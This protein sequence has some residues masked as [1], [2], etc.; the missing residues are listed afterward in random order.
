M[1][2][3]F[4]AVYLLSSLD[5]R[6][7]GFYYVGYTVDPLRRLRQHNGELTNGA[8][9]THRRGRPWELVCCVSGF[10]EDRIALRFEWM[11]QHP[12]K[13]TVLRDR[14]SV[15]GRQS[16]AGRGL[17]YAVGILHLLLTSDSFSTMSLR[18]NILAHAK[19]AECCS[20]LVPKYIPPLV[21]RPN[22]LSIHNLTSEELKALYPSDD[23]LIRSYEAEE[24]ALFEASV[25][26][27][28]LSLGIDA[29]NSMSVRG[30]AASSATSRGDNPNLQQSIPTR[31]LARAGLLGCSFCGLEI[32]EDAAM[33]CP[34]TYR[35]GAA[36]RGQSPPPEEL[37]QASVMLGGGTGDGGGER[38]VLGAHITCM[39]LWFYHQQLKG[40]DLNRGTSS[41]EEECERHIGND[42]VVGLVSAAA[43][44]H[45]SQGPNAAKPTIQLVP[46]NAVP[47]PLCHA[48]T[49][50]VLQWAHLVS[51]FKQRVNHVKA[52][53]A[54]RN[55]VESDA[56]LAAQEQR[57]IDAGLL[58]KKGKSKKTP[59][60]SS[61]TPKPGTAA[62]A[63]SS[64]VVIG[65][66]RGR[67]NNS[68][69][70]AS[71]TTPQPAGSSLL[72]SAT[73]LAPSSNGTTA[74][75]AANPSPSLASA[76]PGHNALASI[77][78]EPSFRAPHATVRLSSGMPRGERIELET[79]SDDD[80]ADWFL[81]DFD[82]P[83]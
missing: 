78:S 3:R 75:P 22:L 79:V 16:Q 49:G 9:R 66:K 18:L 35:D 81:K 65:R 29:S 15:L 50:Q 51:D 10:S 37:S 44:S 46:T 2:T 73:S 64:G 76:G 83:F 26:L 24:R 67:S 82:V 20:A 30:G 7:K 43:C 55:R 23:E 28:G 70:A 45:A 52:R 6:C 54:A 21:E 74:T 59:S 57:L 19:F 77:S 36:Q 47:C 60:S 39:A 71:S 80:E 62:A 14:I 32:E 27:G 40:I 31:V 34:Q 63:S 1:D 12:G 69:N 38:C 5:E 58:T 56:M 68:A 17:T 13:S 61:T 48:H 41:N 4:H 8:W 33:F 53:K 42:T 11:W 25:S 72:P